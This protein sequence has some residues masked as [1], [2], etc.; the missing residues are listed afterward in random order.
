MDDFSRLTREAMIYATQPNVSVMHHVASFPQSQVLIRTTAD[1]YGHRS[2]VER[3]QLIGGQVVHVVCLYLDG[4]ETPSEV[5]SL[6]FPAELTGVSVLKVR[7]EDIV[8]AG[9][10]LSF[11]D[12]SGRIRETRLPME[13]RHHA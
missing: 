13:I 6:Q 2:Y 7:I 12:S 4:A 1:T 5:G 10:F 8:S 3:L 11:R 9:P